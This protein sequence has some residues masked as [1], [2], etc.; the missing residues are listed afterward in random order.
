MEGHVGNMPLPRELSV[1]EDLFAKFFHKG[2][3][4]LIFRSPARIV[5]FGIVLKYSATAW[6]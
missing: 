6:S 2:D 5:S 3:Q 1:R 4:G